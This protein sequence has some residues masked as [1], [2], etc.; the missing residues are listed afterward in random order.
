MIILFH[1]SVIVQQILQPEIQTLP[2]HLTANKV[3]FS[4]GYA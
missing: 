4:V 2:T 3:I 1:F